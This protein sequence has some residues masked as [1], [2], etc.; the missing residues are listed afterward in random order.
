M[1]HEHILMRKSLFGTGLAYQENYITNVMADSKNTIA[2]SVS[3]YFV[4]PTLRLNASKEYSRGKAISKMKDFIAFIKGNRYV[5]VM[6]GSSS[7]KTTLLKMTFKELQTQYVV[8]YCGTDDITGRSQEN[9]LKELVTDTYGADSYS[10]FQAIPSEKKVIII[11]DLHRI[12]SKHLN[13]FL[14]GI[15]DI[16]G[17]IVVASEETSQFDIVQ[18]VKDNINASKEF[19]KVSISRLYAE[20]RLAL[21]QKIV[22]IKTDND[23]I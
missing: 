11:D 23:E 16:F 4:F 2:Q 12:S 7:G 17:T 19:K 21:I 15:E 8:L 9:I 3:D 10:L 14:R 18:M 22:L 6:G 5:A 1:K 13:K 20:K